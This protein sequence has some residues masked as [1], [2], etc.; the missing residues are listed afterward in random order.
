MQIVNEIELFKKFIPG[1][2][3]LAVYGGALYWCIK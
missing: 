1:M 2:N 3:V